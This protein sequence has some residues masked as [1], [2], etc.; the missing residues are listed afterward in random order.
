MYRVYLEEL[1]QLEAR[2]ADRRMVFSALRSRATTRRGSHLMASFF[3][4]LGVGR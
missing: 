2:E 1:A 4:L 3:R